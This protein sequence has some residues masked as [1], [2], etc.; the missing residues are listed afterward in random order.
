M[1]L[2]HARVIS[3]IIISVT[4]IL[5]HN[6]LSATDIVAAQRVEKEAAGSVSVYDRALKL[7]RQGEYRE[8]IKLFRLKK[9]TDAGDANL[10]GWS[11]LKTGDHDEAIRQFS[12]SVSLDP[13][14]VDSYCGLGLSYL[15]TGRLQQALDSFD[16]GTSGNT[17]DVECLLGKAGVL[18][19]L[20]EKGKAAEVYRKVLSIDRDND[21]ARVKVAVSAG[22]KSANAKEDIGFFAKGDYF[23]IRLN[24]S[25]KPFFIKGVNLGFGFPGKYPTEFP[26]D[27]NTYLDWFRMIKEMNANVIRTY[28]ILPPQ[29][30]KALRLFNEERNGEENLFLMQGIWVELPEGDD[31]R[32]SEYMDDVM[33]EIRNAIDAVHGDASIPHR[34]GHSHGIYTDD[35]SSYAAGFI[36]GREW[37][38]N[39]VLAFNKAGK[40]DGFNGRHL[41]ISG[42]SAMEAWLT[43]MLDHVISY[44]AERYKTTRPV[45]FMNWPTLDPL[46]HESEATYREEAEFR[47]K[48]GESVGIID[49]S[50]AF[51][52]DAVA[53]DETRIRMSQNYRSGIFASYHVYPYFPDFLRNDERYG[54]AAPVDGAGY[55]YNYLA[56]LKSRYR[57][58][59]L[60][61]SEYGV[62]TSRGIA[63]FQPDGMHHGGHNE[64]EQGE[65]LQG[66]FTSIREAGAA[67]GI[68]FAMIDE[69]FK[70]NWMVKGMEEDGR[71]WY[72]AQ[73]PEES[74]GLIA[75]SPAGMDKLKGKPEA[76]E[77]ATLLYS[78]DR[79]YPLNVLNDNFDGARNIKGVYAD[80][81]AGYFYIR[82]DTD[83]KPDWSNVA[84]LIAIDT[85][86][87]NEG[88]HLLPFNLGI[89]G[90]D[91]FEFVVLLHGTKSSMLIDDKYN[92][93]EFDNSLLRL[94]GL[95]G[96]RE[97][98]DFRPVSNRNGIFTEMVTAHRRRFSRSGRVFPEVV[99]NAS[100]L[101]HGNLDDDSLADFYYSEKNK[102]IEIRIPWNL[103]YFI[104]PSTGKIVY[105]KGET[106]VTNGLRLM[107]SSYKPAG[108][109]DS[110]AVKINNGINVA[111]IVPQSLSDMK[112]YVWKGW[113]LPEYVSRPK[114][115]YYALK[116]TYGRGAGP[117]LQVKPPQGFDFKPVVE[118]HYKALDDFLALYKTDDYT[119]ADPYGLAL[120]NL[121]KGLVEG[122]PFYILEAR[123]L[124]AIEPGREESRLGMAYADQIQTGKYAAGLN[125]EAKFERINI[126]KHPVA[127]KD[128][129]RIILGRSAIEV[130]RGATIA[131]Q[132][133]RVT[134]DWLSGSNYKSVPWLFN[135]GDVITWHEGEKIREIAALTDARIH[136]VWGTKV[137]RFGDRWYA[138]DADGVYRFEIS[139][140]KVYSYPT[141][142]IVDEGSVVIN[143]THGISA[144]AWDSLNADLAVGCGDYIG[145]VEAAYYLAGK[146][147]NVYMPT[148]RFLSQLIGTKTDG[149]IIG[150]APVKKHEDGAIVGDQPISVDINEK[151]V[152]SNSKGRYPLQYYDTPYL[153]FKELEK[154][155][156]KEMSIIPVDIEEYGKSGRVVD[157]ARRIG[158]KL[159]GIRVAVKEEHDS[160]YKWLSED[161]DNRA[162]LF[163]SAVY[164]EGYKLFFE[165]PA[166]TTFGDINVDFE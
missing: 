163:H 18:E 154:Y 123:S 37:E 19:R 73:D 88:D 165:F 98:S 94:P 134:R 120:A 15:R 42:S 136:P 138:P 100:P 110:N 13:S 77:R 16:K 74:Y 84:Y 41:S 115:S 36:F 96:Y 102:F 118:N 71:L 45:A 153:Y 53:I 72:N 3:H 25:I 10:L 141:N 158:A 31:F 23:W 151:M 130:K 93:M 63:R 85:A 95:S 75:M 105:S 44:E 128:F 60:L 101:R 2:S 34:Y 68:A 99:Y 56:E 126:S 83:G 92:R 6:A 135:K 87:D 49:Y 39:T 7:Y 32:E 116:E 21:T 111:D 122:N 108:E 76:W 132:T 78:D 109:D 137:R 55:Y 20:D 5:F 121:V 86:G 22:E 52:D 30:Y 54:K 65:I 91:G 106:R 112:R 33:N 162:V 43:E 147:V 35:V 117:V 131:T 129:K 9:M 125:K 142:L 48:T 124:F 4:I 12:R 152:V 14:S 40:I 104:N 89:E 166:Q 50:H 66:L 27:I 139:D 70:S 29:F 82:I 144:I 8:A 133:D 159:I 140:D 80:H 26:E 64:D 90:P 148:D 57:R 164:P 17:R 149:V 145:K 1:N 38:P 156:G 103:L 46:F 67:G 97:K 62:P 51:D 150:S 69:W 61:I 11:Y 113:E 155:S 143:D 58:I 28:T 24:E 107:V 160:V 47:R 81:D 161:Q 127:N 157:E 146:G 119:G 114:R 79:K 59:P